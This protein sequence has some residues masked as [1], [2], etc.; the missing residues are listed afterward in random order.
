MAVVKVIGMDIYRYRVPLQIP[1]VFAE[2]PLTQREGLIIQ[3][4]GDD[5][6]VGLG[7]IAPLPG[8]SAERL[9]EAQRQILEVKDRLM[10][11]QIPPQVEELTWYF[12][13]W[14]RS[15]KLLNSVRCG[16][17][18]AILN[19]LANANDRSVAELLGGPSRP[20]IMFSA[21][22]SGTQKEVSRAIKKYLRLGVHSFK[23]KVGSN[24]IFVD[25]EKIILI[26][27]LLPKNCHLR[28]DANQKWDYGQAGSFVKA[29]DRSMVEYLEEPTKDNL[30]L[31]E[32]FKV[33]QFPY[34]LDESLNQLPKEKIKALKGV[35]AFVLKPTLLGGFEKAM[36]WVRL[37]HELGIE[38]VISSSYETGLGI[39]FLAQ[40]SSVATSAPAG[41]DTLKWFTKDLYDE[42]LLIKEGCLLAESLSI[43]KNRID[44]GMIEPVKNG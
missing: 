18:M 1:L 14:L 23:L 41:L 43:E 40:F 42:E 12:E 35:K 11:R 32:F 44:F 10:N 20:Q 29:L 27:A 15:W 5:H 7:E 8:L 37:A 4:T 33:T 24:D 22:L 31:D 25:I 17:E 26:H 16:L 9:P 28:I 2:T 36:G 39:R 34:A 21:L 30:L 38:A 13:T 3:M 19:L 6:S